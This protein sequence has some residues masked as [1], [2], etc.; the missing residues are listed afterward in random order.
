MN[1]S[2]N[3]MTERG[4]HSSYSVSKGIPAQNLG[5]SERPEINSPDR[6]RNQRDQDDRIEDQRKG[7]AF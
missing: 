1:M 7:I 6:K 4:E 2:I 5:G 3:L